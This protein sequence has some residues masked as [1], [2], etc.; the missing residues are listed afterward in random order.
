MIR[1][2]QS[3]LVA[4]LL[5]TSVAAAQGRIVITEVMYKGPG[6]E[7]V[8]F[9]NLGNAVVDMTGW[10]YDDSSRTPGS[11]D[12]SAFGMVQPGESVVLTESADVVF[13]TNW[14]LALSVDV[15]GLCTHNLGGEDEV[16]VYD[17]TATLI[18]RL[19]FGPVAFPGSVVTLDKSASPICSTGEGT[20]N[21]LLWSLS[22]LGDGQGSVASTSLELG[23]P[24]SYSTQSC[25]PPPPVVYCTAKTNSLGC[26]PSIGASGL[27]S[28]TANSGFV[29]QA[30]NLRNN[31]VGILFYTNGGQAAT[32]FTGGFLCVGGALK[33]VQGLNSNGTPA[34]TND[35]SGLFSVDM[36]AFAQGQ[37][38]GNPNA[39]LLVPGTVVDCQFWGRDPG[40]TAPNNTQLT[41]GV[42]YTIGA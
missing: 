32:P 17:S 27:A 14:S 34:P 26:T 22:A 11:V 20:N 13:R 1:T 23:N 5:L 28:A 30:N 36:N 18:D 7:F 39:F 9:T 31:K 21:I 19:T 33:R 35:C 42:E 38:G 4:S 3:S 37:L 24:G 8:E 2:L 25:P 10:S 29:V 6:G 41:D 15:I 40:F 12:L 16:N